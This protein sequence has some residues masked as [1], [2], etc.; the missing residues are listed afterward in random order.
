MGSQN[1]PVPL[2]F[3]GAVKASLRHNLCKIRLGV[4]KKEPW[5]LFPI[6][7]PAVYVTLA[8]SPFSLLLA[9]NE[10]NKLHAITEGQNSAPRLHHIKAFI[11]NMLLTI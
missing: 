8:N 1:L 4:E 9:F 11:I 10:I 2:N 5:G 6:R 7:V 3:G